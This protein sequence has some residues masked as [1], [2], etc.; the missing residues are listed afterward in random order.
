VQHLDPNVVTAAL[1]RA[2]C[3]RCDKP[4]SM[5]L[6]ASIVAVDNRTPVFVLQ[7]PRERSHPIGT[8]R[9]ARLGLRT[10]RVEV[11]WN[12]GERESIAP[13]WLPPD[14]ALLYPS[15]HARELAALSPSERPRHLLVLDGTWHTAHSL[16]RDKVWLQRMPHVHFLPQ[17]E[18]RYRLRKQPAAACVS[19]IEAIVEALRVL[20]PDTA[21]L[22]DLIGAFDAMIEAQLVHVRKRAGRPQARKRRPA[23]VRRIPEALVHG[24]D[25]LV[26]VHAESARRDP[27]SPRTLVQFSAL[28]LGDGALLQRQLRLPGDD[29]IPSIE[30]LD[31]M[32]LD[33]TDFA[34]AVALPS[35]RAE[36]HRFL[37]AHAPAALVVAWNESTLQLLAGAGLAV[38]ESLALKGPYRTRC[39]KEHHTLEDAVRALRLPLDPNPLRGRAGPRLAGTAAVARYL[40]DLQFATPDAP[41]GAR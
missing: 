40:H 26:I 17:S 9:L 6:C 41:H 12:A 13:P 39:G 37:A 10:A 19:T 15:P 5:C 7:H 16:Y 11:A 32:G 33:T 20:E 1:P 14:T 38:R 24:L 27:D 28:A 18:S 2:V 25:H 30:L 8:A 36:W 21:G 23:A 4:Q 35:L 31:H 34:A 29:G 3:Y 22:D